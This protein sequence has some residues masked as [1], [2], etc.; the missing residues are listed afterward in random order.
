MMHEGKQ[1][2]AK[3]LACNLT[4]RDVA[5]RTGL[6]AFTVQ[7]LEWSKTIHDSDISMWQS[8]DNVLNAALGIE[9]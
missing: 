2:K 6:Q 3:R 7:R 9:G 8:I 1:L 4:R 5:D